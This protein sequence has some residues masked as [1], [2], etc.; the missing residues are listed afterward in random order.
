[1][2]PQEHQK[3]QS[4]SVEGGPS[5]KQSSDKILRSRHMEG[6]KMN[7]QY[8]YILYLSMHTYIDIHGHS[9]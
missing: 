7:T 2:N 3:V 9:L 6:R 5:L 8:E 1:M 4:I